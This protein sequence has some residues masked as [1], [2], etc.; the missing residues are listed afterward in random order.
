M[1]IVLVLA[2]VGVAAL[3]VGIEIYCVIRDEREGG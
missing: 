3:A 2:T 1:V